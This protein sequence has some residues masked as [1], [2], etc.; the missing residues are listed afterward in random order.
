MHLKLH[1]FHSKNLI[2]QERIMTKMDN[3]QM[4]W[5]CHNK[6]APRKNVRKVI[7]TEKG[8]RRNRGRPR[9]TWKK[10][11]E[12]GTN[13]KN[14]KRN[15]NRNATPRRIEEVDKANQIRSPEGPKNCKEDNIY[16]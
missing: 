10:K 8:R 9:K 3:R 14:S 13:S 5:F 11:I 6:N 2:K 4:N 15:E 1:N 7:A 12:V 16:S